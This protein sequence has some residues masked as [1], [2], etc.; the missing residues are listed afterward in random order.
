M[1]ALLGVDHVSKRFGSQEV[2]RDVT[3]DVAAGE[4]VGLLGANGAGK[5]TLLRIVSKIDSADSGRIS[6]PAASE[7]GA[8]IEPGWVDGR[9]SCADHVTLALLTRGIRP[10]TARTSAELARVGLAA[11]TSKRAGRLSLGMRQRLALCIATMHRPSLL[12]LD[13]PVNGLDPDGVLWVRDTIRRFASNGGAVL[14]SSHLMAEM[15][16]VADRV[17]VLSGG[18]LQEPDRASEWGSSANVAFTA[19]RDARRLAAPV[20]E[21]GGTLVCLDDRRGVVIGLSAEQVFAIAV[22]ASVVLSRLTTETVSL[23]DHYRATIRLGRATRDRTREQRR[24]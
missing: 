17:V 8:M 21:A 6:G 23:E 12:V 13:E 14:L 5:S 19:D 4:V 24:R 3:F 16:R 11:A 9:L 15:E 7:T 18:S 1:S 22:R 10:T 2:L 20:E